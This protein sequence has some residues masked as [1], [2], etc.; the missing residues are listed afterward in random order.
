LD[1]RK[2]VFEKT[3]RA[4][5]AELTKEYNWVEFW[6][7]LYLYYFSIHNTNKRVGEILRETHRY[8]IVRKNC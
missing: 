4:K 7:S 3:L 2:A 8:K 5:I 6:I 1:S